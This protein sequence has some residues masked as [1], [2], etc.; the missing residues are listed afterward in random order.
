[1]NK[2][3]V[4]VPRARMRRLLDRGNEAGSGG[5]IS[6]VMLVFAIGLFMVLG[7]VIDGSAKARTL[8]HANQLATE[9]ARA[10]LQAATPDGIDQQRVD[11]VVGAY[12]TAGG[13]TEWNSHIVG[14]NQIVVDVTIQQNTKM[15]SM[16]G[17]STMTVH[18]EGTADVVYNR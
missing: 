9:A 7:L 12:L 15:L 8:D 6:L 5:G 4:S 1:M 17:I 11:A 3:K 2:D 10:G 18:G 14:G 13:I 16:V